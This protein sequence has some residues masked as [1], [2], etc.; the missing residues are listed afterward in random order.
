MYHSGVPPL[1]NPKIRE[2]SRNSPMIERTVI[3][4]E[5]PGKPGWSEHAARLM[6]SIRTPAC[7]AA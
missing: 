1:A 6:M 3:P 4:S 7:E 5:R 2:C